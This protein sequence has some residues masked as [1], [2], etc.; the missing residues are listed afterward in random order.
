M[1][2]IVPGAVSADLHLTHPEPLQRPSPLQTVEPLPDT[3]HRVGDLGLHLRGL[4]AVEGDRRVNCSPLGGH[5]GMRCSAHFDRD[6]G[7]G[8]SVTWL[9]A[10]SLIDY[11]SDQSTASPPWP[12]RASFVLEKGR[13][14]KKPR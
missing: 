4:G 9:A 2:L 10:R 3:V 14:P 12:S 11:G 6:V 8:S 13:E 5:G 1:S 7:H